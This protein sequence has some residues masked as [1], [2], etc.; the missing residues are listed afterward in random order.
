MDGDGMAAAYRGVLF[1][2]CAFTFSAA[3]AQPY[4]V[5]PV[6]LVVTYT[7]GGPADIA[8][9]ALAQKLAEM[10]G[11]QVVVDNRAGAGGIIG[12]ELVAKAAPDG[13]TLLHGTAAGLIIN[14]LLVKKLSYDTFRD[15]AP[16]S[17]V[18]IVPQLLVTH[19]AL[20]ATT[21]KELI[22]LAKARPGAL[23]YASVGIGSPNHL[24]MELLKSMAGV[25]MVHVPY[26]GATPAM[27]DLIAGQ[28]QLAF[29]GMASVL[30]QIASG[31]LKAIAIGSARRSPAAPDVPTVAEA[32]LPGFEYVAWNGNFAPAGTPTALVNRLSA[33]IRKALAAPDVVQRLASLG[34]EPGGN[35]P[36]EF[37]AYVKADHARW[38]RVVQTV[39]LKA[40]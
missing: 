21:L 8:A 1:L 28:V 6:R 7:A 11:Q 12:T 14:P 26:K 9:R 31:K 27:A 32:G 19:P 3:C 34:S 22:A 20:P 33:D 30:P 37:A 4:P 16:V 13:Y 39:G 10:W 25:D 29:N 40:E 36:A 15:F 18:V 35:T 23:N 17:M 2:L 24:G 38:A 5:K